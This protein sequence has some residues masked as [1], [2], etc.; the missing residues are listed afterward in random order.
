VSDAID[1]GWDKAEKL[2]S[3][4]SSCCNSETLNGKPLGLGV[5]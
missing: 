5:L 4:F 3:F 2:L 1:T